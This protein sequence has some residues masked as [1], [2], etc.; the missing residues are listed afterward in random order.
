MVSKVNVPRLF[1][2]KDYSL[3]IHNKHCLK[4]VCVKGNNGV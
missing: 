4:I 3:Y 1:V 2:K